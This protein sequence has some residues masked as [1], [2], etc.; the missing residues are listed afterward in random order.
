MRKH[1]RNPAAV[2]ADIVDIV[3]AARIVAVEGYKTAQTAV[4]TDFEPGIEPVD[5][6]VEAVRTAA[7]YMDI[8]P[9]GT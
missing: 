7:A 3:S 9:A 5:T 6:V 1:H 4:D 8:L 2:A